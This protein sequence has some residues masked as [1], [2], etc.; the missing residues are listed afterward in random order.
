MTGRA[1]TPDQST[2]GRNARKRGNRACGATVAL[3]DVRSP[4]WWAAFLLTLI[5]IGAVAWTWAG[6]VER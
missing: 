3:D 1:V 6:E 2:K 5:L 4:L